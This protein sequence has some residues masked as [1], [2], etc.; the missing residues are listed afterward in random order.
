MAVIELEL[1]PRVCCLVLPPRLPGSP[2]LGIL[3]KLGRLMPL[4]EELPP[5]TE[6]RAPSPLEEELPPDDDPRLDMLVIRELKAPK[7]LEEELSEPRLDKPSELP[8]DSEPRLGVRE[9]RAPRPLLDP[10][11]PNWRFSKVLVGAARAPPTKQRMAVDFMVY[12]I[13]QT[14]ELGQE[15]SSRRYRRSD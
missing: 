3:L 6:L 13:C 7:P 9:L 11:S 10:I 15:T 14:R 12:K 2:R 5:R 1:P 8:P 4:E